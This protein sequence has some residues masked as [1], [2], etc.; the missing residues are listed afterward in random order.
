MRFTQEEIVD[1]IL[2]GPRS[3]SGNS[4]EFDELVENY[5]ETFTSKMSDDDAD[6]AYG[7]SDWISDIYYES[8]KNYQSNLVGNMKRHKENTIQCLSL[9]NIT[10]TRLKRI[11][12]EEEDVEILKFLIKHRM[13]SQT[14][15]DKIWSLLEDQNVILR[16]S[17]QSMKDRFNKKIS[18]NITLK[19][20]CAI[21]IELL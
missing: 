9:T 2:N 20:L 3:W 7:F 19:L 12:S 16:R 5:M 13:F 8:W 14:K 1:L 4:D 15:D 18:P 6:L 21:Y 11:Y 10:T 17:G